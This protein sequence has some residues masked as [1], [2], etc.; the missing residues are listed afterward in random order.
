MSKSVITS[1]VIVTAL[2]L[3]AFTHSL[4]D[5]TLEDIIANKPKDTPD[6]KPN[7]TPHQG[8]A[9]VELPEPIGSPE[10]SVNVKVYVTS[11]NECD[12]TTLGAMQNLGKKYLDKVYIE[13]A[14]MVDEKIKS[15]AQNAKIGCLTGITIN[16]KSKFV[17]PE[18]GINATV[19]LDGPVGQQNYHMDDIEAIIAH[20]LKKNGELGINTDINETAKAKS[21]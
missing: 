18:R 10:A 6:T 21:P 11:D 2:V 5:T 17:L 7:A 12:T 19:L 9:V 15:E 8:S 14:D 1:I 3:V 4:T 16:G 13:F 20:L